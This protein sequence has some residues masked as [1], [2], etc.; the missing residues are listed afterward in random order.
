VLGR[1]S[2]ALAR[3]GDGELTQLIA[4]VISNLVEG[5]ILQTRHVIFGSTLGWKARL[6][7]GI[8]GEKT[9]ERYTYKRRTSKR[10]DSWPRAYDGPCWVGVKRVRCGRI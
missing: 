4:S 7:V 3:L 8:Q 2:T 9:H 1:A 10:Q 5:E 6:D